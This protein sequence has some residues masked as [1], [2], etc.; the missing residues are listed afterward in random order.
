MSEGDVFNF[1]ET[2]ELSV[3]AIGKFSDILI[4]VVNDDQLFNHYGQTDLVLTHH[5]LLR[6]AHIMSLEYYSSKLIGFTD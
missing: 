4:T 1:A 6:L 2:F 3:K 5:L